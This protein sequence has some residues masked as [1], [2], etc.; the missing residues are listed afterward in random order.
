MGV[1]H[2]E[3]VPAIDQF[4][5]LGV[6]P[7]ID[8]ES[9]T[10]PP[11]SALTPRESEVLRLIAGGCSNKAIASALAMSER[12]VARHITN[13]YAKIGTRSKSAATAYAIRHG[14]M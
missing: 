6:A 12:T 4:L 3:T 1:S 5:R 9:A 14:L 8:G 7:D 10:A 2:D 13:I 11:H